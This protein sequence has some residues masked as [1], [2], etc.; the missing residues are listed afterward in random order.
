MKIGQF[1]VYTGNGKGKTTAALGLALRASGAGMRVYF[2]QF[3]K[4][5]AYS[6]IKALGMLPNVTVEQFGTGKGILTYREKEDA[7]VACARAGYEKLAAELTSGRYDVVIADEIN[8]ALMCGLLAESDLLRLA[9]LRPEGT[10][11][12]FTGRGATD[13]ILHRA[14]LVTEMHLI[15]HYYQEKKLPARKGIEM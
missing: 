11:L 12:V 9:D 5:Q 6:E 4:D 7:D 14:D 2:C 13:A 10:E 1:Q 8:C 15:K 3:I